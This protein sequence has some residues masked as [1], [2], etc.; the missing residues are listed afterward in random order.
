MTVTCGEN[1]GEL[2]AASLA[3]CCCCCC[4]CSSNWVVRI[5]IDCPGCLPCICI[6]IAWIWDWVNW[7][8]NSTRWTALQHNSSIETASTESTTEHDGLHHVTTQPWV[9][10]NQSQQTVN[11]PATVRATIVLVL[12]HIPHNG[13]LHRCQLLHSQPSVSILSIPRVRVRVIL[14]ILVTPRVRVR[15]MLTPSQ[16]VWQT[17]RYL[18][19]VAVSSDHLRVH[20]QCLLFTCL[21][22]RHH[23]LLRRRCSRLRHLPFTDS[24]SLDE[25]V[26]QSM[27]SLRY[28]RLH[29]LQ[30]KWQ[31]TSSGPLMGQFNLNSHTFNEQY[32]N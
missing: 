21:L 29:W 13:Q 2:T 7:I 31:F 15:V 16:S 11:P 20:L 17:D 9:Y 22:W 3:A 12:Q 27:T 10:V 8:Y 28:N 23:S 14:T 1:S 30:Y 25:K 18:L 19:H 6:V 4:C 26:H 24:S 32:A 5:T